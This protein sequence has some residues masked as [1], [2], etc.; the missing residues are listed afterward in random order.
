MAP[1]AAAGRPHRHE[2]TSAEARAQIEARLKILEDRL[3][4][5][6]RR[7]PDV[8][9]PDP[10]DEMAD[11]LVRLRSLEDRHRAQERR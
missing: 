1:P 9:E 4:A 6:V 8:E 2:I 10:R 7:L 11:I 3:S 5:H